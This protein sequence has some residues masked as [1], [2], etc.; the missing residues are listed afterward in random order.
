MTRKRVTNEEKRQRH[1][2]AM[3]QIDKG[4]GFSEL[5]SLVAETWGCSRRNARRVVSEAHKEWMEIAFGAE[6]I[7]QRDLLFQSVARLERTARK[8]EEAGQFAVVVGCVAQLNKMM[9][10]GADQ[11]GFRGHR[12]NAHYFRR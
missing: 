2:W 9:A 3:K 11:A 8:A 1:E 12:H 6:E 10:L 4:V 5:A 7:D